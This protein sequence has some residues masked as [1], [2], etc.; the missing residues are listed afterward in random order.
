MWLRKSKKQTL[1][2]RTGAALL[3]RTG[4]EVAT[5]GGAPERTWVALQR[6]SGD[7]LKKYDPR[8]QCG[9]EYYIMY[10]IF[11]PM[12]KHEF[13]MFGIVVVQGQKCLCML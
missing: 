6:T 4:G 10:C 2:Q 3:Q 8:A 11:A 5:T 7:D 1:L 13:L 12:Q 9:F